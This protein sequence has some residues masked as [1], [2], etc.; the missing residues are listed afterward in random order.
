[1][2]A[3]ADEMSSPLLSFRYA[4]QETA[5]TDTSIDTWSGNIFVID[6]RNELVD[7]W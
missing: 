7:A 5:D 4:S 6:I 3:P 2:S 1:M